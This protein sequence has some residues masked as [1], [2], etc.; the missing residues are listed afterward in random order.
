MAGLAA[1]TRISGSTRLA[2]PGHPTGLLRRMANTIDSIS[3]GRFG[4]NLIT[5][6]QR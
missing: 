3:H 2:D 5:G 1:V 6:W 4:I